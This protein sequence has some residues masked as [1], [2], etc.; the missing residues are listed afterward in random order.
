MRN[1]AT[2]LRVGAGVLVLAV[3]A[4]VLVVLLR[5]PKQRHLTAYFTSTVGL[6]KGADVRIL[7]ISVGRVTGVKPTGDA[8]RV[9]LEYDAKYKVP[10]NAQAVI[11][12]QTLVSD[13]YVQITPVYK[14][15]AVL[16]DNTTLPVSRT[17]VP[18][19]VDEVTGSLSDLSKA[20]GPEGA[21][22]DG[23]LS[24]LLQVGA[25][26]LSGQGTDIRQ[27]ISDT[28]KMLDTFSAD[29]GD[30]AK[31]IQNLRIITDAMKASDGQIKEF[32]T[33]LNGVSAQLAGEKEELSAALNTL[34]P[35]LRNV[36]RFVKDNRN[37]L[38]TS[39]R[40][41]AQITGVLVKEKGALTEAL[42]AAPLA[43]NNLARAYDPISGTIH[44][45]DNFKQFDNLADWI[46]SLAYSV[47]TPPKQCLDFVT[48][49]NGIGKALAGFSLDL[50][51]ITALTTHYDPVPIPPDAYGPNGKKAT[52]Q[53]RKP[54]DINALLPGGGQ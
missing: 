9:D 4:A 37:D 41:L 44:T 24:R 26:N 7:G 10:A 39:V 8:V 16:A 2:I 6:Y 28:A 33:R 34:G 32:N 22:Q 42:T 5:E 20:L 38:S 36:Q 51:W 52:S 43:I 50:S 17:V 18:V 27:T 46:C 19:E 48:P 30:I 12:N 40:Q 35:T 53:V 45:R 14:G 21:N 1:S 31:T 13:R 3:L 11:V 29:R 54:R 25:N 49:Y 47:G 23:S 15:G